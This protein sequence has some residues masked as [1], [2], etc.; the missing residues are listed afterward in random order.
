MQLESILYLLHIF[1]ISG[2]QFQPNVQYLL[3]SKHQAQS[4]IRTKRYNNGYFEEILDPP[5]FER[6]CTEEF[7]NT[8]E[9]EEALKPMQKLETCSK[10]FSKGTSG[11]Y[12]SGQ[13]EVCFC[14]HGWSGERCNKFRKSILPELVKIIS[15]ETTTAIPIAETET[16]TAQLSISTVSSPLETAEIIST[17]MPTTTKP[18]QIILQKTDNFDEIFNFEPTDKPDLI[19]EESDNFYLEIDEN[20]DFVNDD[21]VYDLGEMYGTELEKVEEFNIF[22]EI[23][24]QTGLNQEATTTS[25]SSSI[26]SSPNWTT[27]TAPLNPFFNSNNDS[28]YKKI[29]VKFQL[30]HVISE[31]ILVFG[32]ND[33]NLENLKS[34]FKNINKNDIVWLKLYKNKVK[35]LKTKK[36][37]LKLLKNYWKVCKQVNKN[38]YCSGKRKRINKLWRRESG[39]PVD[40]R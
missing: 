33:K 8:F 27:T 17:T 30:L 13:V 28:Q 18:S 6:E 35:D 4:F 11:C 31:E 29:I 2:H 23:S 7:C 14:K 39:Y 1:L 36:I 40:E 16:S 15:K 3:K 22:D 26:S 25:M 34:Q 38:G 21:V 12:L 24:T 5:N 37:M 32:Q 10:C 20:F 19:L 9:F